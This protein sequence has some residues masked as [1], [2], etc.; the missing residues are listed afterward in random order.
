MPAVTGSVDRIVFRNPE[1]GFCVARFTPLSPDERGATSTTIVGTLPSVQT[2]EVLRLTGDWQV[3]PIH[4]RNFRVETFEQELPTSAEGIERY[5]ASGVVRGIGPVTARRIVEHFGDRTLD[6]IDQRPQLLEQVQGL[7]ERRVRII[8]ECWT[9]QTKIRELMMFLQQHAI[10]VAL[11]ARIRA[12]YGDEAVEVMRRDPYQLAHEIHGIG[13]RTADA[14]ARHLGVSKQSLSRYVAGLRYTLSSATD[15]GHVF[16][17]HQDLLTKATRIL[18]APVEDLEP[19][20]LEL[21]RRQDAVADGTSIYLAAFYRAEAGAAKLLRE[22]QS[23]PST[24]TLDPRFDPEVA[25]HQAAELQG[26]ELAEKQLAVARQALRE[27]VSVLTGGPGTGKTSTL[28]TIIA[29]LEAAEITYCLCAPTGRAAK[30]VAETTGRAASTIHR[31]LEFQPATETFNYD[32]SRPL[33]YDFVIVDEV[34]MLDILLFYHLMKA[35]PPEAHLLLVGDADQL[36]AV[37]PGNVLRDL[38][39]SERIPTITLTDL[40]RQARGS[41]IV[42]AAHAINQG[43]MPSMANDADHDFFFIRMESEE[44]LV[45]ALKLLLVERIPTRFGLDPVDDVQVI[46]PMHAGPTGVIALNEAMQKWLNPARPGQLELQRGGRTFRLGDKVMQIRNSYDKDVYNGDLGRVVEIDLE[47]NVLTVAYPSAAGKTHVEY[48]SADLDELVLA[49][50]T[51]VHKAQG[52]EFPCVI[53]PMVKRHF[54]MLRRNLVYTAITRARHLCVLLGSTSALATA[55]AEDRREIRN[56][57]L[58]ERLRDTS[59]PAVQVEFA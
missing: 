41:H 32:R 33:P 39:Q 2:G 50:A 22:V 46:S 10:S 20:L 1:S 6:V 45:Q 59:S 11:A 8:R 55:V 24:L 47:D 3:H 26:L 13:F 27:K 58:A 21:L 34:S 36:P 44:R 23:T 42:L 16:M 19:A 7:S 15:D 25:I 48:E 14:L 51:S 57:A 31:L 5:L 30:R 17:K 12:A 37:G 4:G 35:V 18:E 9:E 43:H 56:T 53:M 40:F 29:A 52:S 28:R 38:I 49:Y 54:I